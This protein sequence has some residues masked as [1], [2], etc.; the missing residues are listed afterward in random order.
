MPENTS[1]LLQSSGVPAEY[2]PSQTLDFIQNYNISP[3]ETLSFINPQLGLNFPENRSQALFHLPANVQCINVTPSQVFSPSSASSQASSGAQ[4]A[5]VMFAAKPG[6][7]NTK[8]AVKPI[9]LN[10]CKNRLRRYQSETM[11]NFSD[12]LYAPLR[13]KQVLR[14]QARRNKVSCFYVFCF[15]FCFSKFVEQFFLPLLFFVFLRFFR[16]FL[17]F[18]AFFNVLK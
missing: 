1:L 3:V 14:T 10:Q 17:L 7:D 8:N 6:D 12:L 4:M 18:F 16:I 5:D 11:H 13:T 2:V 9:Y 15:L